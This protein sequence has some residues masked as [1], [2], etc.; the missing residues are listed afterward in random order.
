MRTIAEFNIPYCQFLDAEGAALRPLPCAPIPRN[1][2]ACIADV[3]TQS[4]IPMLHLH[5]IVKQ[6]RITSIGH[7]PQVRRSSALKPR[8]YRA[9]VREIVS[10]VGGVR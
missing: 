10:N 5:A 4:S 6:V 3:L 7:E 2:C 8:L 1:W 9:A